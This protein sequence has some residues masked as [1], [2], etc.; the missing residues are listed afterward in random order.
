[1]ENIFSDSELIEVKKKFLEKSNEILASGDFTKLK[2]K[3]YKWDKE[4][5]MKIH[6]YYKGTQ[7][8]HYHIATQIYLFV[9]GEEHAY[10]K[11]CGALKTQPRFFK[12]DVDICK[13]CNKMCQPKV[14]VTETRICLYCGKEFEVTYSKNNSTDIPAKFCSR[15]CL[16]KNN[17]HSKSKEELKEIEKKRQETN[18]KKYGNKYVVNSE[19]T[20]QKTRE[21][22]GVDYSWQLP[23]FRDKGNQTQIE[24]YGDY[25]SKTPEAKEKLRNNVIS[26]YGSFFNMTRRYK[27]Y[28]MPSGKIIKVQGYEDLALDILLKTYNEDDIV[29]GQPILK[30][31][32]DIFYK[33]KDGN[34]HMYIPDI[35][36]KST[37]TIYEVKSQYTYE[38]HLDD[39]LRKQE[40]CL[41][42]GH[43]FEFMILDRRTEEK[44]KLKAG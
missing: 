5:T 38:V 30:I 2:S 40:V 14:M 31:T 7:Y 28:M 4:N 22:L 23:E 21:K 3:F 24:K 36:I 20:R 42:A 34:K 41:K 25:Y 44:K 13:N 18:L 9:F 32:G 16:G 43:K 12:F 37:D 11:K 10:C 33:D 6:E 1:M 29:C 19:Y 35:Y 27:D 17:Y 8:E 26:R 15:A 39:N